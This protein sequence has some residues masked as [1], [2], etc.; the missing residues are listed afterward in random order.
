LGGLLLIGATLLRR[1]FTRL[2][3]R[4]TGDGGP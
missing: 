4:D 1:H 2:A 3:P